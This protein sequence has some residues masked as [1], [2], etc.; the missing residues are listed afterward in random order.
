MFRG[1]ITYLLSAILCLAASISTAQNLPIVAEVESAVVGSSFSTMMDGPVTYVTINGNGTGDMPSTADRVITFTINFTHEGQYDLYARVR[2]G[3]NAANDDSFFY[4]S[5]FGQRSLSSAGDWIRAN[6]LATVGYTSANEIVDGGGGASGGVWKWINLSKFTADEAPVSFLVS[7][8]ALS[9]TFQIGAREDGF[10][11]DK[12]AFAKTGLFYSVKNLDNVEPGRTTDGPDSKP[13]A[14]G[15]GKFIGNVFSSSQ[16]KYFANYWNQVTP[17]NAG[18]WGS[19]ESQRD[20]MNWTQLDESYKL[21]KDNGFPFKLHVLIWG[22]QQPSWIESLPQSEQ[23]EEIVEWYKAIAARYPAIDIIEVVNEPINDP[24]FNAGNGNYANALG[25][26]GS[27]G[28]DWI[29]EAFRLARENFPS[30]ELMF[31]EYNVVNSDARTGQMIQI[32]NILKAKNLVDAIGVQAHAF[33]TRGSENQ[34]KNN[35][36]RLAETGLPL[37]VTELDIDGPTDQIQL[38]EYKR[39]F[40]IFWEHPAMKGITLWGWRSG[41]WR[42]PE[43][44][45]LMGEDG[46]TERPALVWLREYISAFPTSVIETVKEHNLIAY[47]NPVSGNT[48]YLDNLDFSQHS[49]YDISGKQISAGIISH[50]MIQL[51]EGLKSGIFILKVDSKDQS[52]AIKLIVNGR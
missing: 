32:A 8:D 38:N 17:E 30:S 16:I 10:D 23:Y 51:P 3:S 39:I 41:L 22:N 46:T 13:I 15:K 6:G 44:A 34:M 12:I 31:N 4:G 52:R 5:D 33:S 25:G 45:F 14:E 50:G 11:I 43:K 20:V 37:Y 18:K 24:P 26:Q 28:W 48:V 47:P 29:V 2:V 9:K 1:L 40:P 21:A 19:V 42:T 7:S 27:T 36:D 35:L 49:L